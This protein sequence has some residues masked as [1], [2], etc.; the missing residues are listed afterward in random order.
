[1]TSLRIVI[2]SFFL[3][4]PLLLFAQ[5]KVSFIS[6]T[7]ESLVSDWDNSISRITPSF[8]QF[9]VSTNQENQLNDFYSIHKSELGKK[10]QS[11]DSNKK[12]AEIIFD[13]LHKEVFLK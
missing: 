3:M 5:D 7:E 2:F 8:L 6:P 4:S 11:R 13:Y 1:M 9:S 10:I 12:K